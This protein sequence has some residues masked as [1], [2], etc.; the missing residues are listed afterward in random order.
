[1]KNEQLITAI[2]SVLLAI[3]GVAILSLLVSG[4]S[5][6]GSVLTAGGS[7]IA[8]MICTALSPVTGGNCGSLIPSVSSTITFGGITQGNPTGGGL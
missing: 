7:G 3:V 2:V 6:T 8:Q 5:R 1:M 4:Q